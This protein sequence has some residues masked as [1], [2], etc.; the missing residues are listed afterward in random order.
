M[1]PVAVKLSLCCTV[2]ILRAAW[3]FVLDQ[4]GAAPDRA[5]HDVRD[6]HGGMHGGAGQA[7]RRPARRH[8]HRSVVE[9]ENA[10]FCFGFFF[11]GDEYLTNTHVLALSAVW[12]EL[13][14]ENKEFFDQY[15]QWRL[16]KG[17]GSSSP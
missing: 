16:A 8:L 5:V 12:K 7:R 10:R 4:A 15:K 6:E 14:K 11:T 9:L 13:E 2:K 17:S 3:C 1:M